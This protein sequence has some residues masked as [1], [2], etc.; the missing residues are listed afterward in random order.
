MKI[1][2]GIWLGALAG[3]C[4]GAVVAVLTHSTEQ[5][6]LEQEPFPPL[7]SVTRRLPSPPTQSATSADERPSAEVNAATAPATSEPARAPAL[8]GEALSQ[9]ELRC[10]RGAADACLRVG[11]S[12]SGSSSGDTKALTF[13]RRA[14]V[15][16]AEGCQRREA[17][18]CRQLSTLY[19][20]GIGV[21]RDANTAAALLQR[22]LELC[23]SSKDGCREGKP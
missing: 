15:L 23:A 2:R 18:A 13:R 12:Y 19:E 14:L 6:E 9:E 7:S 8:V 11:D 22:Y 20:H 3:T 10:A 16:Y 1:D 5:H 4:V 17:H 21:S